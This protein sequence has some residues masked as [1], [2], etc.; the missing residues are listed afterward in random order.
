MRS[1]SLILLIA[2]LADAGTAVAGWATSGAGP[3]ASR[4]K[5]LA[6]PLAPTA[7]RSGKRVAVSWTDSG[8]VGGGN[9]GSF[10]VARYDA[11]TGVKQTI[12]AACSGTITG[13]NC[14]ENNVPSGSWQYTIT[15]AIGNWRGPESAKSSRV[16]IP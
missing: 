16:T 7:T 4:A 12:G 9:V 13:T 8:F 14:T 6:S 11:T 3:A 10:L 5:T 15:P 2:A 1:L